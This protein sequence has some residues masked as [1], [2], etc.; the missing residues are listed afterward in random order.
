MPPSRTPTAIL[1]ARGSWRAKQRANEPEY[2]IGAPDRPEWLSKSAKSE[3]HRLVPQLVTR[4][5]LALVDAMALTVYCHC[6]GQIA[7]L[8]RALAKAKP[9]TV[10]W[11]RLFVAQGH[12]CDRLLQFAREFGLTPASRSKIQ[13]IPSGD[14]DDGRGKQRFF[15][16]G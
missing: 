14:D 1:R 10:E 3:W 11:K 12:A 15:L 6:A 2:E 9:G 5:V 8:G 13:P 16:R 4:G 7:D